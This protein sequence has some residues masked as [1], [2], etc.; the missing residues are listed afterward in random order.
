MSDFRFEIEASVPSRAYER[1]IGG[2]DLRL[3]R[4]RLFN[5]P[6]VVDERGRLRRRPDVFTDLRPDEA[7]QFAF[8][9]L[10]AAAR[11]RDLSAKSLS[12]TR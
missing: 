8:E 2:G 12:H 3:V 10:A 7:S 4:V 5:G 6:G 11:A 9:L 1:R